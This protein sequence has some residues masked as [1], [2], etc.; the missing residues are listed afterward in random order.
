MDFDLGPRRESEQSA[1]APDH[2]ES[3][4][5]LTYVGEAPEESRHSHRAMHLVIVAAADTNESH[6]RITGFTSRVRDPCV[7]GNLLDFRAQTSD[8]ESYR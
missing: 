5:Y 8:V 1:T 4:Q 7:R 3:R 2:S 6:G